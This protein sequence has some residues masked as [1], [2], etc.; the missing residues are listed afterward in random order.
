MDF[1]YGGDNG[2]GNYG[3]TNSAGGGGFNADENFNAEN[4]SQKQLIIKQSLTPVT[5]KQ[6]NQ[7]IQEIPDG[8][9]KINNVELNMVEFIGVVRSI[10]DNSASI[11]ITI[12]DGSGGLEIRKW[13]EETKID[14]EFYQNF[15]NKYVHVSGILKLLNGKKLVQRPSIRLIEDHNEILYHNLNAISIHLKSQNMSSNVNTNTN[16]Q[17]S[18]NSLFVPQ[19]NNDS[20]SDKV[21]SILHKHSSTMSEGV[22]CTYIAQQLNVNVD[23][24]ANICNSLSESGKIYSGYDESAYL[25]L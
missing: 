19:D 24:V 15:L 4:N 20:L 10:K 13:S 25:C 17:Q 23:D 18:D 3:D 11:S 6:I 7:S 1:N 21:L 5:I 9:F 16:N 14:M 12:E 2:Y 22:P 8:D